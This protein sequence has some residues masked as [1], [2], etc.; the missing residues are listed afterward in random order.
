M[1]SVIVCGVQAEGRDA[2]AGQATTGWAGSR[3]RLKQF[4]RCDGDD[5]L[6]CGATW[7]GGTQVLQDGWSDAL[8]AVAAS[9]A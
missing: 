8:H 6:T 3:G 7:W 1:L 4:G 2:A 5:A 9:N